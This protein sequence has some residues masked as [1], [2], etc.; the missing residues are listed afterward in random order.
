MSFTPSDDFDDT[1]INIVSEIDTSA[2]GGSDVV[3]YAKKKGNLII[4]SLYI[5]GITFNA[6][7]YLQKQLLKSTSLNKPAN[8]TSLNVFNG[9]D[10]SPIVN[11]MMDSSGRLWFR[12][13]TN[14]S[15]KDYFIS[16]CYYTNN[17]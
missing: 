6:S 14:I 10:N 5:T 3:Y 4:F 17:P 12:S 1:W 9:N 8:Y 13:D 7:T 16:G 11:A 15:N 2:L